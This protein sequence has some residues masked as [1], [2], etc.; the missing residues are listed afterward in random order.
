F[1]F[2]RLL[3]G[4]YDL[5]VLA[6]GHSAVRRTVVIDETDVTLELNATPNQYRGYDMFALILSLL[7]AAQGATRLPADTG[8]I[9]GVIKTASG[10]PASGVRVTAQARPEGPADVLSSASFASLAETDQNGR[11]RLD[12]VPPGNYYIAAGRMGSQTF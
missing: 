11:Y 3:P 2:T 5:E 1:E 10:T 12:N 6:F 4:S 7:L 8:T 9:T